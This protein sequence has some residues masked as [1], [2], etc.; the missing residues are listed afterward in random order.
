MFKCEYLKYIVD[1]TAKII[2][3][4]QAEYFAHIFAI[5]IQLMDKKTAEKKCVFLQILYFNAQADKKPLS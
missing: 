1:K 4:I 2:S 5:H 3:I